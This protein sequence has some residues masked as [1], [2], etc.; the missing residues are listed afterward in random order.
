MND[1]AAFLRELGLR[2]GAIVA[3]GK[4]RRCRTDDKPRRLNGA[5]WLA[6][7]GRL[8]WGQ[9]WAVHAEPV[10]WRP[11]TESSTPTF[12]PER[13]R[14][15]WRETRAKARD[16]VRKA[17]AFYAACRPLRGG[18]PYLDA[19]GLDMAGCYGLKVD[20]DGWLVIPA[21]RAGQV[22]TVQ[23]IAPD[24]TKRFWKGAPIKGASYTVERRGAVVTVLCEGLAT[25]LALYAA[26]PHA[27]VMVAFHAGNLAEVAKGLP[28]GLTVVAADND[29]GTEART[30]ENPGVLAAHAAADLLGCGVAV[31]EGM[32]GTD[33]CDL[34]NERIRAR[35]ETRLPHESEAALRR[36][37]DAEIE[38]EVMRHAR[39]RAAVLAS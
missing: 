39:F 38:R 27:R 23:R 26:I 13:L 8:G 12:D 37:V 10:L 33:W 11:G 15:T 4:V 36:A 32:Q 6:P 18:H 31:P 29:H 14:Q 17:R 1:F 25:G 19:H 7:D 9:N 3:D 16:A 28:G 21:Y 5:Y 34:R 20:E 2:P 24:G 35:L 22:M 30:G